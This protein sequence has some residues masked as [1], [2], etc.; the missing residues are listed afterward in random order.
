MKST[1]PHIVVGTPGR[2]LALIRNKKL[3]LKQLKHFIL[4]EC[5]KML[6]QLGKFLFFYFKFWKLWGFLWVYEF[7]GYFSGFRFWK[8]EL[9]TII[10][11]KRRKILS[12]FV[13]EQEGGRKKITFKKI[14]LKQV[15]SINVHWFCL[16]CF[17]YV[18][19]H[20]TRLSST[21][22]MSAL[23]ISDRSKLQVIIHCSQNSL[24]KT[25]TYSSKWTNNRR[26]LM[27]TETMPTLR[28]KIKLN[29]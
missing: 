7:S 19:E 4:D 1:T 17:A 16:R 20:K 6:E 23:A 3:N 2:I 28:I 24:F 15:C 13:S 8:I 18:L 10:L 5:D 22:R 12:S 25:R 21:W 26:K 9:P 27:W 29:I 11:N 14:V